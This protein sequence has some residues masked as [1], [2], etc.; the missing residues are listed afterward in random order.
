MHFSV[1]LLAVT[2]HVLLVRITLIL[3]MKLVVSR[4]IVLKA[5]L[6]DVIFFIVDAAVILF[7]IFVCLAYHAL[8]VK[9]LFPHL[10]ELVFLIV[11]VRHD[12]C[13]GCFVVSLAR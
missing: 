1:A 13:N 10:V 11:S 7:A 5:F 8:T 6:V 9:L 2:I 12:S 4:H 3:L